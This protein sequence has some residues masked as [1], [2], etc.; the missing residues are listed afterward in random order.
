MAGEQKNP[1]IYVAKPEL[2]VLT[3]LPAAKGPCLISKVANAQK[4][5]QAL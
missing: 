1:R 3:R 2:T 5:G 4:E